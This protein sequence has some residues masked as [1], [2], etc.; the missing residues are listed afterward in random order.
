M[1]IHSF[2]FALSAAITAAILWII[3]A[4]L[5]ALSPAFMNSMTAGMMHGD[6]A[7]IGLILDWPGFLVGLIAWVVWSGVAGWLVA[8]TYNQLSKSET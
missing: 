7:H 2:N 1:R 4:V 8:I 3:C 6:T 5:V